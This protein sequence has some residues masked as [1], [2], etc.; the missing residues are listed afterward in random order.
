[1]YVPSTTG[2]VTNYR[3]SHYLSNHRSLAVNCHPLKTCPACATFLPLIDIELPPGGAD[4]G[5]QDPGL[6]DGY[7]PGARTQARLHI[8]ALSEFPTLS[9]NSKL[10]K[11]TILR[12]ND[13]NCR[14]H[15]QLLPRQRYPASSS[16]AFLS[17]YRFEARSSSTI[18][19]LQS[20]L[21]THSNLMCA[22]RLSL[23]AF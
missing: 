14:H 18:T 19:A 16:A 15:T 3:Y 20:R 6:C 10:Y 7:W 17:S 22:S 12:N 1:M 13:G 4:Y 2:F 23:P 8:C 9:I 5:P 11:L 21:V